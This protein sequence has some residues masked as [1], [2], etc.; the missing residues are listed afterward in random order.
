[1]AATI[2]GTV[3]RDLTGNG[4]SPDDPGLAGVVVKLFKD[5]NANG[6]VDVA[7]G[8]AVATKT[9][10]AVTGAFAFTGLAKGN[11]LLQETPGPNQV[12]TGPFLTDTIA[13]AVTKK[14]GTFGGNVFANYV[15]DFDASAVTGITYS[16]NG[17]APVLTMDG[18]V[19]AGDTVTVNFTV[20]AGKTVTVSLVSY[21]APAPFSS[22]ENLQDQELFQSDTGTFTGGTHS[23]T[24]KVPDCY[25]Q[26]DFVGGLPI[27]PFGPAG[28]DILYSH[29][30]R[31]IAFVNGGDEPCGCDQPPVDPPPVD[32]PC[33]EQLGAE[34]LTPGFWKNHTELWVGYSTT[35]TL[36]SVFDVPDSLGLDN[37]TLLDALNF[38]GGPGAKGAAQNLFRH[39]VAALLNAQHPLVDYPETTATIVSSVNSALA[40]NSPT[41]MALLKDHLE[42][43]NSLEGGIDAHGREI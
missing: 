15:K 30:G 25:F 10:A 40:T 6:I 19:H 23:L 17:G 28:S 34:G 21:E 32:P 1:M 35:Q 43:M 27:D 33:G 14:N 8:A 39:A 22:A 26:L 20:A 3:V 24:V 37:K 7:D 13:V 31:R 29:Q 42:A 5:K 38:K 2:A 12:R 4:V 36:E 16:I 9:S 41:A 11:Y 18:N